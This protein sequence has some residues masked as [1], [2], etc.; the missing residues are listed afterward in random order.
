M[1]RFR[2][3]TNVAGSGPA[4]RNKEEEEEEVVMGTNEEYETEALRYQQPASVLQGNIQEE[5]VYKLAIT[6]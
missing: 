5:P 6:S 3:R 2:I 4:T 1:F